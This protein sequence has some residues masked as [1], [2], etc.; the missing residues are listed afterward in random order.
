MVEGVV[1]PDLG[2]ATLGV[3]NVVDG[4]N[5]FVAGS[6]F[7]FEFEVTVEGVGLEVNRPHLG[8]GIDVPNAT[9]AILGEAPLSAERWNGFA[10]DPGGS[11]AQAEV[12]VGSIEPVIHGPDQAA[13][14]ML[15]VA[16]TRATVKP[17]GAFVGDAIAVVI[18]VFV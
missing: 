15:H 1:G 14:L 4:P 17:E 8:A 5:D 9:G 3:G 12:I 6:A 2:G 13:G 18:V 7:P 11:G 16:A 10:D